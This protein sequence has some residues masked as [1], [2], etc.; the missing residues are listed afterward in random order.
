MSRRAD[1]L[2]SGIILILVS[3]PI[4]LIQV[5]ASKHPPHLHGWDYFTDVMHGMFIWRPDGWMNLNLVAGFIVGCGLIVRGLTV[6]QTTPAKSSRGLGGPGIWWFV[7]AYLVV[8]IT[9]SVV[10]VNSPGAIPH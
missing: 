9:I 10:L 1:Y 8:F 5:I 7:A 6:R 2:L 3:A 4:L